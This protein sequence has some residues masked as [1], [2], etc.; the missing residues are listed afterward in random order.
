MNE[1]TL[2]SEIHRGLKNGKSKSE[3]YEEYSHTMDDNLLRRILAS[4]PSHEVKN[5]FRLLHKTICWIWISIFALELLGSFEP[6]LNFDIKVLISLAISAYLLIQLWKFNGEIYLPAIF[7]L[8]LGIFN[9]VKEQIHL[10]KDD[11]DYAA[12]M[13]FSWSYILLLLT[14]IS[15]MLIVRK[16]VFGY[17]NL[18]KPAYDQNNKIVFQKE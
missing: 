1:K 2:K 14:T 13:I 15:L 18:F 8:I 5:K 7:W 3:L 17:Y 16:N 10:P 11:L 9:G 6:L 12:M 4:R